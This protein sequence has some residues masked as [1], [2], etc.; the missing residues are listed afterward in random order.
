MLGVLFNVLHHVQVLKVR[1][2]LGV[3][4]GAG[5]IVASIWL[6]PEI[7]PS[8]HARNMFAALLLFGIPLFYL[9]TLAS[10][11]EESEVEI[12]AI[13]AALGISLWTLTES[14]VGG[15]V[16]VQLALLLAPAATYY[17]YTRFVLPELRVFKHVLRGVSYA[18]VGHMGPALL[19][20][21]R[22]LHLNPT[23]AVAREQLWNVHR[24]MDFKEIVKDPTTLGLLNFELCLGRVATLLLTAKP[25]PEHLA[26][27]GSPALPRAGIFLRDS[28]RIWR[29]RAAIIGPRWR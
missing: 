8:R 21:G 15:N 16:W 24:M 29:F 14:N 12:M 27:R 11:V 28:G 20:L 2:W 4:L 26:R 13:C 23:N 7:M 1:R 17:W 5:L 19:S 22:A 18:N 6:L 9:L 10:M 3:A 25:S